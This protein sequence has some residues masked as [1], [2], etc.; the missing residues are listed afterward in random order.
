VRLCIVCVARTHLRPR[1]IHRDNFHQKRGSP[2]LDWI[3]AV[4][5]S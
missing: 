1:P 5:P 2:R 4:P 3:P